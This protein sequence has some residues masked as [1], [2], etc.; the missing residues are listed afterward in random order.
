M[1]IS[2]L[3]RIL[4]QHDPFGI[5]RVNGIK[6]VYVLMIL[7]VV[8]G[9]IYIPHAYFYFFYVPL[10]GLTA[11]ALGT[12]IAQKYLF[13]IGV[14]LGTVLVIA[15]FNLCFPFPLIFLFVVF[16]MVGVMYLYLLKDQSKL[17]WVPIILSLGSYSL[18][19]RAVNGTPFEIFNNGLT[20][21]I[22]MLVVLG[23]LALFPLS[24]YYRVWLRAFYQVANLSLKNFLILQSGALSV[25]DTPIFIITMR[26][27]AGMLP[28]C[29]PTYSIM[30]M[31]F[32]IHKMYL[33]SCVSWAPRPILTS[34]DI[35]DLVQ[36]LQILLI[37]IEQETPCIIQE[38]AHP[39]I[40]KIIQSW[41]YCV[42]RI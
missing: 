15:I 8:N 34:Q 35:A 4:E 22:S 12:T 21:V 5:F 19:Y 39:K 24:F 36:Q 18:N 20:I 26:T 14:T 16:V 32:H 25:T 23:A 29:F 42:S 2:K 41:N 40:H 6:A 31:T 7:S 10:T 33:M 37:A 27:Y 30:N 9:A 11:E 17:F 3:T 1:F 28:R 13:F 38:S